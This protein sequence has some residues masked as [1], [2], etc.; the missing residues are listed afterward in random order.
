M[1]DSAAAVTDPSSTTASSTC[2]RFTSSKGTP[3]LHR[4]PVA[5]TQ[6]A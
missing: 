4:W 3:S 2:N 5:R 1:S 6:G